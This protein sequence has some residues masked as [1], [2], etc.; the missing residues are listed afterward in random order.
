MK[1]VINFSDLAVIRGLAA[2]YVVINHARGNLFAGGSYLSSIKELDYFDKMNLAILQLT[3]LG[4][5][6]V[7]LFFVLSG[8]SIAHSLKKNKNTLDFIS[9]RFVRIYPPYLAAVLLV[10]VVVNIFD[11]SSYSKE[12]LSIIVFFK[13]LFYFESDGGFTAQYWS[14]VYEVIFYILAPVILVRLRM[15]K[16]FLISSIVLFSLSYIVFGGEFVSLE[17]NLTNFFLDVLIYFMIGVFLYVKFDFF[18]ALKLKKN[19]LPVFIFL[20]LLIVFLKRYLHVDIKFL[21]VCV[22]I[23]SCFIIINLNGMSIKSK[24][25]IFFGEISYSLYLNHFFII[26]LAQ[27]LLIKYYNIDRFS[28]SNYYSWLLS[29]PVCI[30]VSYIM[31][32]F[33]ER[34]CNLYLQAMRQ[35]K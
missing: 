34:K 33:V 12:Y 13:Y 18:S 26:T 21:S 5:E 10:Y 7:I 11:C 14:L 32:Y 4:H 20:F 27:V 19:F 16:I 6:A 28:I 30:L 3:A 29:V 22:A 1:H 17:N 24:L 35:G 8:F 2:L 9:K 31:W 15:I 23:F 25:L